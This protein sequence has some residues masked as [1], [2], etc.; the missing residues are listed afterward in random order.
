MRIILLLYL[1]LIITSCV[2]PKDKPLEQALRESGDNRAALESVIDHYKTT[3]SDSL[4]L[5]AA[6][7][8]IENMHGKITIENVDVNKYKNVLNSL[9]K[10]DDPYPEDGY[11]SVVNQK[12]DSILNNNKLSIRYSLDLKTITAKYLIQS[13]DDAFL[14]WQS[15]PWHNNYTFEEF[16][17]FVLPYRT[18]SERLENWR[19]LAHSRIL[20]AEDS[21]L[22]KGLLFDL[23]VFLIDS[24]KIRYNIGMDKFPIAMTLSD[25]EVIKIGSCTHISSYLSKLFRSCSIPSAVDFVPAWANRSGKHMWNVIILQN[26]KSKEIGNNPN[27]NNT[28]YH[29]ISKIYRHRYSLVREDILFKMKNAEQIPSFFSRFDKQDITAQYNMPVTDMLVNNLQK[30]DHK[31][32]WLCTFNN[33]Q[34]V[35]VAYA[36]CDADGKALFKDMGQG[37]LPDGEKPI[38]HLNDGKGIAYLPA[39]YDGKRTLPAAAARILHED[40]VVEIMDVDTINKQTI[41]V[42]RKYPKHPNFDEYE[43]HMVGGRFEAANR[44]DFSDA[45]TLL[46]I[47]RPQAWQM[48]RFLVPS[49]LSSV[50][51]RYIRYVAPICNRGNIAELRFYSQNVPL[52]G[53]PIGTPGEA[54]NRGPAALFDDNMESFYNVSSAD[55]LNNVWA[56]LD[57]GKPLP[58]TEIAFAARTDDN[59]ICPGDTYQ[60]LYW[61]NRWQPLPTIVAKNHQISWADVPSNT[62]YLLRNLSRGIEQRPFTYENETQIWW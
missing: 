4:K 16:C 48:E 24:A 20:Q 52:T 44:S 13:I 59:E 35:P 25:M 19:P 36:L 60:L 3:D 21:T 8:L 40:G 29:K 17:E 7:F 55:T 53:K 38:A 41:T 27:G 6:I 49:N 2:Q 42:N 31:I 22:S 62:L 26:G 5:K 58:I 30:S 46:T 10:L 61:H 33:S 51:Y 23:G 47:A 37:A 57:L 43:K 34:W 12:I 50:P 1:L 45:L 32:A 15:V 54:P 11:L 9:A 14:Q 28:M 18:D 39:Y 56:G